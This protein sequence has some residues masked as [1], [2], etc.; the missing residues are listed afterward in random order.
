MG[1]A[2]LLDW[3]EAAAA[4]ARR[5]GGKGWNLGGLHRYGFRVPAG[6]VLAADAY[7]RH[8]GAPALAAPRAE[9]ADVSAE[10]AA[11]PD[12]ATR[13]Q[14]FQAAILA[15]ALP[16]EV[17]GA[18]RSFLAASGLGAVPLAVRSSATAE[19]SAAASFAG[20]HRSFLNQ[21]GAEQVIDAVKGCYASLWTPAALAYRRRLR[22]ADT[23]VSY[24]VVLCAMVRGPGGAPAAAGWRSPA[25]RAPG[26]AT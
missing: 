4:G 11:D 22:L 18:V 2:W 19:D 14:A 8:L 12:V 6:A 17:E 10:R 16:P 23:D 9:L 25:T 26:G 5:C 24:A 21:L 15:Q 1:Q 20:I 7:D 13:L 3:D